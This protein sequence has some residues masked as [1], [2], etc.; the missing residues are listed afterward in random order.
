M[1]KN[2]SALRKIQLELKAPKSKFNKF[3][4]FYYRSCEDILEA[5]KPLLAKYGCDLVI[6]DEVNDIA[7]IAV[8]TAKVVFKDADG[9]VTEVKAH[10]GVEAKKG[11]DISQT[12]GASST[13]ARKYALNGLF[14]IDDTQDADSDAHHEQ[15]QNAQQQNQQQRSQQRN[16]QAKQ[17]Q[18]QQ[19]SHQNQGGAYGGRAE[20]HA[21]RR[22]EEEVYQ[23]ALTE[24]E[25]TT[26]PAV[27]DIALKRFANTKYFKSIQNACTARADQ[28]GWEYQS[29]PQNTQHQPQQNFHH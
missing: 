1:S 2:E 29:G 16:A 8:I 11:M 19:S 4:N 9:N 13:Y 20:G 6:S 24:I 28:M 7:N 14:L 5:V 27:L 18:Q 10:A 15:Q 23:S 22:S 3:G 25:K 17:N 26:A 21:P 12:F